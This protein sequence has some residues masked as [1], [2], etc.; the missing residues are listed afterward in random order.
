MLLP[1]EVHHDASIGFDRLPVEAV[2]GVHPLAG[3]AECFNGE[4]AISPD[5]LHALQ[6]AIFADGS[7]DHYGSA[8]TGGFR[9]LRKHRIDATKQ[10]ALSDLTGR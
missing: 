8:N 10:S 7:D 5:Q 1:T 4:G 2:W 6:V 9:E 3:S